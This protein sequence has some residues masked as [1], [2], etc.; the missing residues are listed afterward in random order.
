MRDIPVALASVGLSGLS[1]PQALQVH[2]ELMV[3][4][5]PVEVNV[6]R[7]TELLNEGRRGQVLVENWNKPG[8]LVLY[9][10]EPSEKLLIQLLK[11]FEVFYLNRPPAAPAPVTNWERVKGWFK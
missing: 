10:E 7:A 1:A 8:V 4:L 9:H 6:E 2:R 3:V 11:V 5:V